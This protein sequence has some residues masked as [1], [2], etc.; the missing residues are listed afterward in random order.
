MMK[1]LVVYDSQYGNTQR[2][3]E[4]ITRVIGDALDSPEGATLLRASEVRPE[5][6]A[7]LQLLVVGAPT[8]RFRPTSAMLGWLKSLPAG[9]L[10]GV[11][12]AAFDTRLDVPKVKSRILSFF[13][14]LSGPGAYAARHIADGLKMSGGTLLVPPEGFLV[15]GTEG[16][17]QDGELARAAGWARM[18]VQK[19]EA[20]HGGP[21]M[22]GVDA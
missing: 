9:S 2:V 8:Q 20:S 18:L 1:V 5:H 16:P 11:S 19:V 13:V 3:A 17:L 12:V 6:L 21:L 10:D 4:A 15:E 14:W 7:G 22:Q